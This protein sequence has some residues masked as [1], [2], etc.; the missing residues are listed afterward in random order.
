MQL[1]SS[2][3][4]TPPLRLNYVMLGTGVT[5]FIALKQNENFFVT[6]LFLFFFNCSKEYFLQ[7]ELVKGFIV[8]RI[9]VVSV[10]MCVTTACRLVRGARRFRWKMGNEMGHIACVTNDI[11]NFCPD[12]RG[13]IFLRN[14]GAH[15][16][17][18]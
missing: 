8:K 3:T 16:E 5:I 15:L 9:C 2:F 10:V 1:T 11:S 13:S 17:S 6:S 4:S 18:G 14:V 12:D 7:E